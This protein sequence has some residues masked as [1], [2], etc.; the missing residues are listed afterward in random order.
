MVD[1]ITLDNRS[2]VAKV[3][4]NQRQV[5]T[6]NDVKEVTPRLEEGRDTPFARVRLDTKRERHKESG[7]KKKGKN[8]PEK[9]VMEDRE[10]D[11][12][13]EHIDIVV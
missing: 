1:E 9:K 4:S 12:K 7:S 13:V 8:E 5:A 2:F 3:L 6:V 11:D 10:G